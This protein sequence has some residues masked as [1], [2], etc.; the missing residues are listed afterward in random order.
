[1]ELPSANSYTSRT[2]LSNLTVKDSW[3]YKNKSIMH[4]IS[5]RTLKSNAIYFTMR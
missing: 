1:M 5:V 3:G 2:L 4:T